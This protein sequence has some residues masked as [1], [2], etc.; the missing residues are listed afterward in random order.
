MCANKW[1]ITTNDVC[2]GP[3]ATNSGPEVVRQSVIVRAETATGGT[4]VR[5]NGKSPT[6]AS[7]SSSSNAFKRRAP[8]K[9]LQER[10]KTKDDQSQDSVPS[11]SKWVSRAPH[12]NV[13]SYIDEIVGPYRSPDARPWEDTHLSSSISLSWTVEDAAHRYHQYG[14]AAQTADHLINY[15]MDREL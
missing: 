14:R 9:K 2:I 10:F 3:S 7:S 6:N 1:P 4:Y 15:E 12:S 8:K 13:H 5:H 11:V